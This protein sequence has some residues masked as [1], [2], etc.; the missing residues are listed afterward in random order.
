MISPAT[1]DRLRLTASM[2]P[3]DVA[4]WT[5]LYV[6]AAR[7]ILAELETLAAVRAYLAKP[8]ARLDT[9]RLLLA[10]SGAETLE[11]IRSPTCTPSSELPQS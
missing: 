5:I 9:L 3:D 6:L 10:S 7:E 1:L 4:S 11:V 8:R 2:D